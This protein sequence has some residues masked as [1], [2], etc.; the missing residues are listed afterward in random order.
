MNV[1]YLV[2]YLGVGDDANDDDS[3]SEAIEAVAINDEDDE[4]EAEDLENFIQSGML[5][6]VCFSLL[7]YL[8]GRPILISFP[9]GYYILPSRV[10]PKRPR[11]VMEYFKRELM[12]ST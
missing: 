8:L 11:W 9:K 12:I 6:E 2:S 5:D 7:I 4:E 10:V 1:F 3:V